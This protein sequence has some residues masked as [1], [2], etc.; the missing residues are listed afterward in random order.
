MD[1]T[2]LPLLG[3]E[4]NKVSNEDIIRA[5]FFFPR[6]SLVFA[7]NLKTRTQQLETY[8]AVA[9][10][11]RMANEQAGTN[12]DSLSMADV[13]ESF[14]LNPNLKPSVTDHLATMGHWQEQPILLAAASLNPSRLIKLL[15]VE[16]MDDSLASVLI[17]IRTDI[18]AD[19][20]FIIWQFATIRKDKDLL[21]LCA[22]HPSASST[23]IEAYFSGS[24][25]QEIE[26]MEAGLDKESVAL[27]RDFFWF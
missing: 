7:R 15:G 20:I 24:S 21:R 2:L 9:T 8:R 22:N 11:L 14:L 13:V 6:L 1:P 19:A 18:D 16:R 23:M 17:M 3:I 25:I 26:M 4:S 5:V 27:L 10:L 12:A